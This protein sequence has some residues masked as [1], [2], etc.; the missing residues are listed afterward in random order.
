MLF[1]FINMFMLN[2]KDYFQIKVHPMFMLYAVHQK[3][4]LAQK[5][6]VKWWWNLGPCV[7]IK[8]LNDYNETIIT[9]RRALMKFTPE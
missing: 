5:L 4:L 3:D 9:E 8:R 2:F 1:Y 6:I 7:T